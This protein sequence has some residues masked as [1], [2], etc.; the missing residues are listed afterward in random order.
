MHRTTIYLNDEEREGLRRLSAATGK[1][2]AEL[3]RGALR[4]VLARPVRRNFRSMGK[5][6]GGGEPAAG[7][8]RGE[9]EA[10]YR[11][12]MGL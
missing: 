4:R 9:A 7:I 10:L 3:I 8:N 2:Q 12:K 1:S 11:K 6:R 5:G